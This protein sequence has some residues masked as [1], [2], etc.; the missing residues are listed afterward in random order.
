MS[1]YFSNLISDSGPIVTTLEN[2]VTLPSHESDNSLAY[3]FSSFSLN[4]IKKM[5]DTFVLSGTENDVY[6]LLILKKITAFTQDSEDAVDKII[7][8]STTKSCLLDP[9]PNFS[10]R[11]V[12]IYYFHQLQSWSTAHSWRVVSL[13]VL[14]L[15]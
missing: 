4:K 13:L 14:K 8:K 2:Y 6:L 5:S 10:S 12:V 11:N 9:W 3:Q 15:L 1:D 7:R